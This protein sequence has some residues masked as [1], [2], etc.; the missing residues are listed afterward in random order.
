M[1]LLALVFAIV[2]GL[3]EW[4]GTCRFL[5]LSFIYIL[6]LDFLLSRGEGSDPINRLN[7]FYACPKTG[8]GFFM[9]YVVVPLFVFSR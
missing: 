9:L 2:S 5:F 4:K 8:A 6:A 7:H 1:V 3:F